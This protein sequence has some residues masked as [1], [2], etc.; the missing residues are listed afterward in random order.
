M[1]IGVEFGTSFLKIKAKRKIA[2]DPEFKVPVAKK[3]LDLPSIFKTKYFEMTSDNFF[4]NYSNFFYD[5]KID[6]AFIDGLHTYKQTFRDIE[7][8]LKY[9]SDNGVIVVHDCNPE[10]EASA[11]PDREVARKSPEASRKWNGD[12]W[13]A[14]AHF[15]STRNDLNIFTL[16]CDW[17]LGIII[18]GRPESILKYSLDE[19]RELSYKDLEYNRK[20]ILNLKNIDYFEEFL[21]TLKEI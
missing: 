20:E 21:N 19:L 4:E 15:R 16:N 2:I 7:N 14:I 10:C 18:K 5:K 12:T 3:V 17:G 8:C 11:S 13:K 9:L 1:E 6:V